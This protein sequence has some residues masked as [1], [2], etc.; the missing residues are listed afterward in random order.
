MSVRRVAKNNNSDED[1]S[2][3]MVG[4]PAAAGQEVMRTV[5]VE[6]KPEVQEAMDKLSLGGDAGISNDKY[7]QIGKL[8]AAS[9]ALLRGDNNDCMQQSPCSPTCAPTN[10]P[11]SDMQH[12]MQ[13]ATGVSA[14][15]CPSQYQFIDI[16]PD[17]Q[18]GRMITGLGNTGVGVDSYSVMVETNAKQSAP[19][20]HFYPK[21]EDS[22]NPTK[23]AKQYTQL[24]HDSFVA[25]VKT[26]DIDNFEKL[27]DDVDR[28]SQ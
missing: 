9:Q 10:V 13:L 6:L 15:D 3:R 25:L 18:A 19:T 2:L 4:A 1:R 27:A 22:V 21:H 20:L 11:G 17:S 23:V 16:S 26:Y 24:Q 12:A 28:Q 7:R 8:R 5:A 14:G